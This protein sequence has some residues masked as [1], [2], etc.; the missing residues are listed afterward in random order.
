MK[1][2]IQH[3]KI[4]GVHQRKYLEIYKDLKLT[5][6]MK[7]KKSKPSLEENRRIINI[8]TG[9]NQIKNKKITEEFPL[10]LSG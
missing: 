7:L 10:W 2:K 4:Y 1:I 6:L 8:Q 5:I 3:T 9:I